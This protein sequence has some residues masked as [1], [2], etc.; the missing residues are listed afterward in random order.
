MICANFWPVE[1]VR[2]KVLHKV[3]SHGGQ[4]IAPIFVRWALKNF[5]YRQNVDKNQK[6][7]TQNIGSIEFLVFLPAFNLQAGG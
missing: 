7:K 6:P 1:H 3:L 5:S 4:G 2:P